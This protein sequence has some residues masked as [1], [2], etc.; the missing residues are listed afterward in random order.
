MTRQEAEAEVLRRWYE[1]PPE[2]RTSY[3]QAEAFAAELDRQLE[4]YTVTSRQRLI[5]AW[6]I[7]DI[8]RGRMEMRPAHAA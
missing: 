3:E 2:A 8:H 6:L 7:R 4:F 1:L 5:A